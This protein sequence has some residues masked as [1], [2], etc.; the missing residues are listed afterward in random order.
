MNVGLI[1]KDQ[2]RRD[3]WVDRVANVFIVIG[4][5]HH[6]RS[7]VL[8]NHAHPDPAH[9]RPGSS[10]T[11]RAWFRF[12][13]LPMSW[14]Y[15]LFFQFDRYVHRNDLLENFADLVGNKAAVPK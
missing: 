8:V 15:P 14:I 5:R 4:D 9:H 13:A 1:G 10:R 3:R 11:S 6:D 2:G 12:T 7:C